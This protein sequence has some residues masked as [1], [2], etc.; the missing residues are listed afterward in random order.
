SLTA[1]KESNSPD[2]YKT[3]TGS[4]VKANRGAEV[5]AILDGISK[6]NPKDVQPLLSLGAYYEQAAQPAKAMVAYEKVLSLDKNNAQAYKGIGNVY[7]GQK[8]YMEALQSYRKWAGKQ[9][10]FM[11][12]DD[13]E[14]KI[15]DCLEYLGKPEKALEEYEKMAQRAPQ[16]QEIQASIKRLN[17]EPRKIPNLQLFPGPTE[18]APSDTI[19]SAPK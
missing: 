13:A 8:K 18:Q 17:P 16:N 19:L 7:F 2:F 9:F 5:V 6:K 12:V 10:L 4:Y 11:G 14:I 1:K 3:L 15:A